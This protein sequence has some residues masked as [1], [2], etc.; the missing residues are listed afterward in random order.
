M[1][2]IQTLCLLTPVLLLCACQLDHTEPYAWA[3]RW[4]GPEGTY[5]E[6]NQVQAVDTAPASYDIAIRDLDRE[7]RYSGH[8]QGDTIVFTR[9]GVTE[10]IRQGNGKETGMKWLADKHRCLIIRTGEG[11]CRN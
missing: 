9:N 3:G 10:T 11:Y 7:R 1:K 2:K 4:T 5:L 8:A 6:L